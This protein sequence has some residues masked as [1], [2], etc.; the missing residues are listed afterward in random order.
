MIPTKPIIPKRFHAM[1]QEKVDKF[2]I[3]SSIHKIA[4]SVSSFTADQWKPWT[5]IFFLL[6]VLNGVLEQEHLEFCWSM[7][8]SSSPSAEDL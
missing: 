2:E 5:M 6:Y 1:M 4:S 3:P 7:Q 8:N